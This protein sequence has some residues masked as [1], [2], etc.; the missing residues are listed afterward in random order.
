MNIIKTIQ[1]GFKDV[2][3]QPKNT[4]SNSR[5]EI[6]IKREFKFKFSKHNWKG[7][8]II[9]YNTAGTFEVYGVLSSRKIITC[10]HKFYTVKDF[11]EK[12]KKTL[13]DPDYFMISTDI[14]ESNFSNLYEIISITKAKWVC[15]DITNEK[16]LYSV[17]YC[18]KIRESFPDIIIVAGNVLTK[19]ATINL[20]SNGVDCVK[21]GPDSSHLT[22]LK[23]GVGIPQLTAVMECAAAAHSVGG[24]IISDGLI[25]CPGD[26]VK[27]FGGGADFVSIKQFD[28]QNENL[29]NTVTDYLGGIRLACVYINAKS[30]ESIPKNTTFL[31]ASQ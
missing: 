25:T 8:P 10:F 13:L 29:D 20:I 16:T 1:L 24:F 11:K 7:I 2:M 21:I 14:Q 15:I 5:F 31:I 23:T 18:K 27:A 26:V 30:I 3:I 6:D 22:Y 4:I 9:G 12:I 17:N 19:E 28:E